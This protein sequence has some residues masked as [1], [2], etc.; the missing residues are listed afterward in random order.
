MIALQKY[1]RFN[2]GKRIARITLYFE[3]EGVE[4]AKGIK[5]WPAGGKLKKDKTVS[6]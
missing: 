5:L 3:G 1:V 2:A 4:Y 6:R